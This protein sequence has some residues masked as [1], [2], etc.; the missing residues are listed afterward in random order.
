M[1]R[2]KFCAQNVIILRWMPYHQHA[3]TAQTVGDYLMKFDFM[4]RKAE[5]RTQSGEP[6]PKARVSILRTQNASLSRA[7]KSLGSLMKRGGFGIAAVPS[8][9]RRS[10]GPM[11]IRVRQDVVLARGHEDVAQSR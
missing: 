11:S 6:F 4:R 10:F 2:G 9:M 8:Q 3:R 1:R 7:D 5:S